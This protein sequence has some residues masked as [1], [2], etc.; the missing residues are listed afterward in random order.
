LGN[1]LE[2]QGKTIKGNREYFDQCLDK[3]FPGLKNKSI[4]TY[5]NQYE[6]SSPNNIGLLKLVIDTCQKSNIMC[7]I[8]E[9]F[10][11][12]RDYPS[13]YEQLSLF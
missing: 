3:E 8:N 12:L 5:G 1:N 10:S 2:M 4:K 9:V 6:V 13:E 7:N 11:Y